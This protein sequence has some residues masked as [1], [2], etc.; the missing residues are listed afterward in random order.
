MGAGVGRRDRVNHLLSMPIQER[1]G[2]GEGVG[3]TE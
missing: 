2:L 3:G 1:R